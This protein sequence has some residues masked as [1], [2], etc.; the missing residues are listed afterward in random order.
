MPIPLDAR[1]IANQ[2]GDFAPQHQNNWMLEIAGLAGDAKDL[3]VLSLQ[4]GALPNESSDEVEIAYGNEKRYAAG[5]T[6]YETIPLVIR[7]WVDREVRKAV[8]D[9]R[10][11]VYDPETGLVGLPSEYKKTADLILVASNNSVLRVCRLVGVWP[12]SVNGGTLDMT[13]SEQVLIEV[14]LRYDRAIW[15]L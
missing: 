1:H 8:Q 2:Q 5:Q 9:W 14:N 11:L 12:Q 3:I 6:T 4:S 7:D 10:G 13:S 15:D